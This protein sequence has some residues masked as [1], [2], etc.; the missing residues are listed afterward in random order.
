MGN[1]F[2]AYGIIRQEYLNR[3]LDLY[4]KEYVEYL[5]EF[6]GMRCRIG[7]GKRIGNGLSE[8]GFKIGNNQFTQYVSGFDNDFKMFCHF[9]ADGNLVLRYSK[10]WRN[11]F[12]DLM[13]NEDKCD[14]E[15]EIFCEAERVEKE[16]ILQLFN[17]RLFDYFEFC[18][19]N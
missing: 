14:Y 4:C 15:E 13:E 12:T 5:R 18:Q 17:K 10:S 2:G 6:S 8:I 3:Q 7:E 19:R 11:R 16:Y 1:C 9:N